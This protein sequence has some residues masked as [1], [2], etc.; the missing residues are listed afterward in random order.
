[1]NPA[2]LHA[3]RRSSTGPISTPLR[4]ATGRWRKPLAGHIESEKN[5]VQQKYSLQQVSV[6]LLYS[7]LSLEDYMNHDYGLYEDERDAFR[8]NWT[9]PFTQLL[10]WS[11]EKSFELGLRANE[12][13]TWGD[14]LL[15]EDFKPAVDKLLE[16]NRI[17]GGKLVF[18][19]LAL[20][21]ILEVYKNIPNIL[22]VEQIIRLQSALE[23]YLREKWQTD[24]GNGIT[25]PELNNFHIPLAKEFAQ[26]WKDRVELYISKAS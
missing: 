3:G 8:T 18:L 7:A 22:G 10:N 6:A 19:V 23:T 20:Y 4:S 25:N 11:I 5:L 9:E 1:M 24:L 16:E 26:R 13:E 21:Y 14:A 17:H 12:L 15:F 2:I